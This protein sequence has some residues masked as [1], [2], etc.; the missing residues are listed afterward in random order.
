MNY[1]KKGVR[2]RQKQLNANGV[3]WGRKISI[4]VLE[5]LLLLIVSAG[6]IGI[7]AG[8]GVFKGILATAPDI[9]NIDVSPSGYST[10]V[11]DIE[12]KQTAKLVSAD[13]NR[14]PKAM[15]DIPEDL[16]HA[17]VA[18]EDE[19]FY[20]HNGIDIQGIIRAGFTAIKDRNLSQGASTITQQLLKNNVFTGWTSENSTIDKVKRKIQ[21][22]YLALELEKV[23]DKDTILENYMNTINLGQNTLGVQSASLRYFNKDVSKLTLSECA[24]IAGI[25]QNPS[26]YNPISRPEKNAERRAKVLRHM[27]EQGYITQAEY[28]EA[29]ADNVYDR[30]QTINIEVGDDTI[31]SYF[32]DALVDDVLADLVEAGYNENQAFSL[33]YSGGLKIYSTQD[34]SIQKICDDVFSNEENFPENTKWE[35][36]YE[37]TIQHP[38]GDV[39]NFSTQKMLAWFKENVKST[40][41]LMYTSSEEAYAD[42]DLYKASVMA[43]GDEELAENVTLTPQPQVSLTIQDQHTGHVVA[44]IGGRGSKMAS[45]TLNRATDGPRQPGSTFKVVAAY[46]PA[47]DSAGATLAD[48]HMDEPYNYE[49][50]RPVSNWY[51][52]EYRGICSYRDGIR[53]SLNV[54]AVKTLTKI[55]PQ[56]GFDYLNSF[57]FTTL[58]ANK[59]VNNQIYSDIQQS[60]ALGGITVGVTNEELNAAYASIAN[61]GIYH[62]PILYTKI[63]DHDGNL[64]LDKTQTQKSRRVIKETTAF[65]LT[66]A[67]V[68]VV[69][70]GTGG[71]VN[72]GG[73]SIAGKTGTTSDYVD[74]WFAGYTPYYT[75]TTWAGF[76]N[77]VTTTKLTSTEEKNLA[78]KLWREVMSEIHAELPN[79]SFPIPSGITTA[80][81][82]SQSGKLPVPGLCDGTLKTEY[83]AEGTVPE[84][85]CNVHYSGTIC[86]FDLLPASPECPFQAS[87]VLALN[88][89]TLTPPVPANTLETTPVVQQ[90]TEI[91]PLTGLPID[92]MAVQ[93]PIMQCQ[94]NALFFATPGHEALIQAQEHQMELNALAAQQAAEAAA[95]QAALLQQQMN[96]GAITAQ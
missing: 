52:E 36:S 4:F 58:V 40:Y 74:V 79:Q 17:F 88:P 1:G 63:T 55:T 80:T 94:H 83:F 30:I 96:A 60:L 43:E 62:E 20:E 8:I 93:T 72:F 38:N 5:I 75:A 23:M 84:T 22:Q 9:S 44:M 24:V 49:G 3:R 54:I 13:S 42:I 45:R 59:M 87:G 69:T 15:E 92:P 41:K 28:D 47:L 91:D 82:C 48:V 35:L 66:D 11:Y 12:G 73:M 27:L 10:F 64:I 18:I 57:G 29:L 34:P 95:Q 7:V 6:V 19:R 46:A 78:K 21:E 33:L 81:V 67:M 56:L 31:N 68:D 50:G 86:A 32:V 65:L 70:S 25:T 89:D 85:T 51:G 26:K 37:L 77:N 39:E 53:D 71:S 90:P 2:N 16:A 76:D 61:G 14:I